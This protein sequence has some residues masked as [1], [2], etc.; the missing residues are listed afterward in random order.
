[1][2]TA[3]VGLAVTPTVISTLLSH[4]LNREPRAKKPTAHLSYDQGLHLIRS[5]LTYASR[6]TVE[7]L[8]AFTSQWVPHPQWVKVDVVDVSERELSRAADLLGE[9]LG[10]EGLRQVGG[11]LWWQ[12]RKEKSPLKAEWIEMKSDYQERLKNGDPGNRVMLYVH[13]G[14]YYFGSV[15]EHRYQIQRHARKLK[16]RALAPRYRLAPQFP[17]PCG[18]QD[19]LATY[20][21]LLTLQESNTIILAGDS[22]GA[23]MILSMMVILRDQGLPLPAGAVLISPWADLTH[24]FPSVAGDCPLDYI[25]PSGFHHKPSLA[26]PPPDEDELEALKKI[27]MKQKKEIAEAK[28]MTEKEGGVEE[29]HIPSQKDVKEATHKLTFNIDGEEITVREQIQIYTTND[30]LAHPLVSPIMQPTL[31]GLPPLLIMVGGG[32]VLRDEQIYLAHKCANPSQY[33]PPEALMDDRAKAQVEKYEP[34]DVYLQVWDDMCHVGPTLSFTRP[35]KYMYRSV[36]QFSAWA[37]ARAQ[38]MEIDILDDDQISVISTGTSSSEDNENKK[39]EVKTETSEAIKSNGV[40]TNNTDEKIKNDTSKPTDNTPLASIGKSSFPIPPFKDHMIR[41]RVTRHGDIF[42][43]DPPSSLPGC[44]MSRDLVGVVKVGT[45]RK[46]YMHK[47]KW[48]IKYAKTK[49]RVHAQRIKDMQIGYEVFGEG[50]VPPPTALAGR[51]KIDGG[52]SVEKKKGKGRSYGLSLWGS[53]GSKHDKR[54]KGKITLAEGGFGKVGVGRKYKAGGEGD[55][56]GEGARDWEDIKRQAEEE[57]RKVEGKKEGKTGESSSPVGRIKSKAWRKLVKDEK[58]VEG[59][60]EPKGEE[61]GLDL[62][63]AGPMIPQEE[64]KDDDDAKVEPAADGNDKAGGNPGLLSPEDNSTGVTG[65]RLFLGGVAMPFSMR[66][67]AETASMITLAPASPRDQ[68]SIRLS[69]AD[70]I[71]CTPLEPPPAINVQTAESEDNMS[72]LKGG[73]A[74][75]RVSNMTVATEWTRLDQLEANDPKASKSEVGTVWTEEEQEEGDKETPLATPSVM[76]MYTATPGQSRPE[77]DRFVTAD[78]LPRY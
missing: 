25:P 51:R 70:S 22:A 4:Y 32:E 34:T 76:T 29:D 14:A 44:T 21:Y 5:F 64:K 1:M 3:S 77:L 59:L 57:Y 24:S 68:N 6:H 37:L 62:R 55:T 71:N 61:E 8:Q 72:T 65:K 9:Q 13:G 60:P 54:T 7:D 74:V 16:A 43:L 27:A 66:K 53:W 50:E 41:H 69:I 11:K 26:W 15:D 39:P 47:K 19:C 2:H 58:V 30:L 36:A 35:A 73:G 28:E 38:K 12:W 17:F 67:E 46:W 42:P 33:L 63:P 56:T 75:R 49:A 23:G 40:E 18:L 78:E 20:L 45:V 52:K 31:G 48:D 10:P